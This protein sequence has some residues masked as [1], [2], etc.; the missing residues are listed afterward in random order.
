MVYLSLKPT[1]EI[2]LKMY[3]SGFKLMIYPVVS[4]SARLAWF[5][6]GFNL[7]RRFVINNAWQTLQQPPHRHYP[8]SANRPAMRFP[9]HSGTHSAT[10]FRSATNPAAV[11]ILVAC[12]RALLNMQL[13][14]L[15]RAAIT[16]PTWASPLHSYRP[17]V[18]R[19]L[20]ETAFCSEQRHLYLMTFQRRVRATSFSWGFFGCCRL[21]RLLFTHLLIARKGERGFPINKTRTQPTGRIRDACQAPV[22]AALFASRLIAKQVWTEYLPKNT[23]L[24]H[25]PYYL[26]LTTQTTAK[27]QSKS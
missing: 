22:A 8:Y 10:L 9:S 19:P 7:V 26:L 25:K 21:A 24:K 3:K 1:L 11:A 17:T 16:A 5:S 4:T 18:P 15:K 23:F 13:A 2:A 6:V 14:V 27:H 12:S 20:L